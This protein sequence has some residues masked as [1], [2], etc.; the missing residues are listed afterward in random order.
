LYICIISLSPELLKNIRRIDQGFPHI[1]VC[2]LL[3]PHLVSSC[4]GLSSIIYV[5]VLSAFY[6]HA[7][8]IA[9]L[10]ID[11]GLIRNLK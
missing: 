10:E 7:D 1:G 6:Y 9:N 4:L 5:Y 2:P 11:I 8:V 3:V